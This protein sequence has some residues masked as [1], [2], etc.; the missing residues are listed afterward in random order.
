[1]KININNYFIHI[2]FIKEI[3]IEIDDKSKYV[4]WNI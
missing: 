3:K 1:M 4:D 2:K